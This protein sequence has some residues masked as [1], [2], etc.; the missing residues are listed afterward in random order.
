MAV[1][2]LVFQCQPFFFP[3]FP[4]SFLKPTLFLSPIV[5]YFLLHCLDTPSPSQ[6]SYYYCFYIYFF[7]STSFCS[8]VL[9]HIVSEYT[10][11]FFRAAIC[12][13][14]CCFFLLFWRFYPFLH[15]Q[16]FL[17]F[18]IFFNTYFKY[19]LFYFFCIIIHWTIFHFFSFL[20]FAI[21][22]EPFFCFSFFLLLN[23]LIL[24]AFPIAEQNSLFRNISSAILSFLFQLFFCFFPF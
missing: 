7:I 2:E 8:P 6:C 10:H 22:P 11:T 21:L 14:Y 23:P 24:L 19:V 5:F 9:F 13:F 17:K 16:T 20:H 1:V 18:H 12:I 3:W 4:I 15:C